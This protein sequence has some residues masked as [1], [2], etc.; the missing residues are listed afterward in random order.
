MKRIA[1]S[2]F[3]LLIGW[4]HAAWAQPAIAWANGTGGSGIDQGNAIAVDSDRNVVVA[5]DFNG[6]MDF[7]PGP[8]IHTLTTMGVDILVVKFDPNGNLMWAHAI[9]GPGT[10]V[11]TGIAADDSGN[12]FIAGHFEQTVDFDPGPST[13]NFTSLGG[14]DFVLIK[15]DPN[16]NFLWA[17]QF[18]TIYD[19]LRPEIALDRFGNLHLAATFSGTMDCDPGAATYNL[20]SNA[21]SPDA[22]V[23]KLATNG[24][25]IWAKNWG[26]PGSELMEGIALDTNGNVFTT[27][28]FDGTADFDPGP[29]VSNLSATGVNKDIFVSKLSAT[30]LYDWAFPVGGI[31]HD[32]A[33]AITCDRMNG[34]FIV[35]HF[36]GTVDFDP[37]PTMANHTTSF[38]NQD[39]FILK[40]NSQGNF[41]WLQQF[42]N[43]GGLS[44]STGTSLLVDPAGNIFFTGTFS[45]NLDFDPGPGTHVLIS[46]NSYDIFLLKMNPAGGLAWVGATNSHINPDKAHALAR[47]DAGMIYLTGY[48]GGDADFDMGSGVYNLQT[49][50]NFDFFVAKYG[51]C[52]ATDTT[53]V[54][55]NCNSYTLNAQTYTSSGTYSQVIPNT[56]GCDSTIHLQLTITGVTAL[57][58][59]ILGDSIVCAGAY[60]TYSIP[61]V[62][63]ATSYTW[64]LPGGWTG[65]S[66]SDTILAMVDT[67]G[68]TI[69]VI[70]HNAC[71]A[72]PAQTLGVMVI[73]TPSLAGPIIGPT[74]ICESSTHTY[75]VPPAPGAMGYFWNLPAGWTG[76]SSTNSVTATAGIIGGTVSVYAFNACGSSLA[77]NIPV[78]V[79]PTPSPQF[80]TSTNGLTATFTNMTSGGS[81]W[82]WTFGDGGT[83]SL[84]NPVHTYAAPGNYNVSLTVTDNG[85]EGIASQ[86]ISILAV[87]ATTASNP[88]VILFP[89]PSSGLFAI[90]TLTELQGELTDVH[91]RNIL[92]INLKSGSNVLNLGGHADGIYFLRLHDGV[93]VFWFRVVKE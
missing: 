71:G 16:G 29:G 58:G 1:L 93:R 60:Y 26:G 11:G 21:G 56:A 83:S 70:A 23:V 18:G 49:P 45:G 42:P 50:N 61:A 76:M 75:S 53:L 63:G 48:Y 87:G 17:K 7:D 6:S 88:K 19:E 34:V 35:G 66:A 12:V 5:G 33:Y 3:L 36:K 84:Q 79:L 20:A 14:K 41:R 78:T 85:C 13:F 4:A 9:G 92:E 57:P 80:T 59:P 55:Q 37:G 62:P 2:F 31:N 86:T 72:S 89:N 43:G 65:T 10:D 46:N 69:S 24:S 22:F 74:S 8:G 77:L 67:S 32:Y 64:T 40:V 90:E 52:Q 30:G 54:A 44:T 91:G 73:T 28:T 68:G 47:D 38:G 82:S 25:L 51:V 15:L 39:V 27:G 81:A